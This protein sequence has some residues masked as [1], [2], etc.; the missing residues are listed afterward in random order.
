LGV[1]ARPYQAIATG[2]GLGSVIVIGMTGSL[3][4]FDDT[5]FPA[6]SLPHAVVQDFPSSSHILSRL[7]LLQPIAVVIG[8]IYVLWLLQNFWRKQE[9]S[10]WMLLLTVTLTA[11]IALGT[12]NVILLAPVWLQV[13][14]LLVAEMFWI[15]FVLASADQLFANH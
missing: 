2:L 8:S 14:H 3:A 4:G 6:D 12:I 9:R 13:T 1:V 5:I 10:P 11:Q 7:R 15:L